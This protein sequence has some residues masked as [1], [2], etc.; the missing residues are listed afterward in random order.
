MG[1]V[2]RPLA[3]APLSDLSA[4]RNRTWKCVTAVVCAF[5][6]SVYPWATGCDVRPHV[7]RYMKKELLSTPLG[8]GLCMCVHRYVCDLHTNLWSGNPSALVLNIPSWAPACLCL[9][10]SVMKEDVTTGPSGF[11]YRILFCSGGRPK[12]VKS[13]IITGSLFPFIRPALNLRALCGN[14][15]CQRL[16]KGVTS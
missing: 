2:R 6:F 13:S 11:C 8:W 12:A 15:G 9:L 14:S 4:S 10:T 1:G 7:R 16:W 3:A 5:F